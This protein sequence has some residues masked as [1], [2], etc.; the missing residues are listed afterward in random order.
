M[1]AWFDIA[2]KHSL[3]G[4]CIDEFFVTHLLYVSVT[5][6]RIRKCVYPILQEA[7]RYNTHSDIIGKHQTATRLNY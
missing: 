2:R 6:D 4:I 7:C 1:H 3:S 5:C